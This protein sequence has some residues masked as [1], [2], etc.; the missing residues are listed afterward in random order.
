MPYIYPNANRLGGT[1]KVGTT[2]CVALVQFYANVPHHSAW[3]QGERVVDSRNMQLGTAIATFVKGRYP[4]KK[5]GNHAAFFL[6]YDAPGMG[7]WE[8]DQWKD[9]KGEPVRPVQA[10]RIKPQS[11]K[12]NPDGSWWYASSNA[13]AFYVIELR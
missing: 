7:F 1:P 4:S 2:D 9:K 8:M 12:Q 11:R 6:R 3:R 13:D 10:R 5:T